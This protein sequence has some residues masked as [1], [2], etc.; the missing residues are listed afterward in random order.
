MSLVILTSYFSKKSHPQAGDPDLKGM[1]QDG[2]VQ[3][4]SLDY[5]KGWYDSVKALGIEGR[6]FYDNLDE[7]LVK[8]W[9]TPSIKFIKVETSDYSYNDWR[10]FCYRNYLEENKFDQV[11]HTDASDVTVV[12]NPAVLFE[13]FPQTN[14]F[15]CKDSI[16][17]HQFPY[18]QGHK[19]LGFENYILFFINQF[20]WDL[21]N[22]GVIGAKYEDM[23]LFL[24][25][26]CRLRIQ[27]GNPGF[28]ADIWTANYIFRNLLSEKSLLIGEPVT[29]RFKH[30]EINRRDVFF[31]HK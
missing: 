17:L 18:L 20:E 6:V 21:I 28:N 22:N 15:L 13:E 25:T 31:I 19:Q 10:F 8:Q 2:R 4:N 1:A 7:S 14:Y 3:Q 16:K 26:I 23:M 9:T 12:K 27:M 29:S 11:F 30:Y 24:N 5:I